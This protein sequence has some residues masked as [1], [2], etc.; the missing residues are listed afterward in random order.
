VSPDKTVKW[1]TDDIYEGEI[2]VMAKQE[3]QASVSTHSDIRTGNLVWVQPVSMERWWGQLDAFRLRRL[4]VLKPHHICAKCG[5][6]VQNHTEGTVC[7][8]PTDAW[9]TLDRELP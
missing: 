9:M 1:R 7:G 2:R 3:T 4:E 8:S 5:K 6:P